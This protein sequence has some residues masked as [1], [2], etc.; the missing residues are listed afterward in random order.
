MIYMLVGR[1]F[2]L[3]W[4]APYFEILSAA[5][6]RKRANALRANTAPKNYNPGISFVFWSLCDG[7]GV[8]T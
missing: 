8:S 5:R 6:E 2:I 4:R 7:E 3:V 1:L